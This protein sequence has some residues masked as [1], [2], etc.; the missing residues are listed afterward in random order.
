MVYFDIGLNWLKSRRNLSVTVL[1]LFYFSINIAAFIDVV[2][3]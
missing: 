3:S 1:A 2:L